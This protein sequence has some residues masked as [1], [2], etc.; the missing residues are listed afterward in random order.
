MNSAEHFGPLQRLLCRSFRSYA[1]KNGARLQPLQGLCFRVKP[2]MST[3]AFSSD[4]GP[5]SLYLSLSCL[6]AD[7]LIF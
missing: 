3:G 4:R 6:S 2:F 7:N 1:N 5:I